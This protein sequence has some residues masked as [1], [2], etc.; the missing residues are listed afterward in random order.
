LIVE[1]EPKMREVLFGGL[2]KNGYEIL[3]A[4]N[5]EEALRL[6]D[7]K[8]FDLVITDIKLPDRDGMD[9][10]GVIKS[11][12]VHTPVMMMTG[13]GRFKTRWMP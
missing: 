10:L 1:D 7:Q 8:P 4:E 6:F 11:R 5:G 12:S 2:S 3:L 13:F 9:L